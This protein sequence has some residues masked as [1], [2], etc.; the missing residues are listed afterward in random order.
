MVLLKEETY[1]RE[2]STRPADPEGDFV[3]ERGIPASVRRG[4][5]ADL[6]P[7]AEKQHQQ[8]EHSPSCPAAELLQPAPH[9]AP[10]S[11]PFPPPSDGYTLLRSP[12]KVC[13]GQRRTR[14][15]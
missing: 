15:E 10:K 6:Q 11:A 2:F 12:G 5:A 3:R 1:Q 13:F 4:S 8:P 7:P 9:V 14:A